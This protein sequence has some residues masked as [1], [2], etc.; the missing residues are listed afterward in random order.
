M[1]TSNAD[2][3]NGPEVPA[4]EPKL[5]LALSGGGKRA[6]LFS[7]GALLA[8]V[9]AGYNQST[10]AISSVSGGSITNGAVATAC[11]FTEVGKENF[12][13]LVDDL[14]DKLQRRRHRVRFWWLLLVAAVYTLLAATSP[15]NALWDRIDFIGHADV[16]ESEIGVVLLTG[17]FLYVLSVRNLLQERVISALFKTPGKTEATLEDLATRKVAHVFCLTDLE[18]GLPLLFRNDKCLRLIADDE[19]GE[20]ACQVS[21]QRSMALARV[22]TG[23]AA[24]PGAFAPFLLRLSRDPSV[25]RRDRWIVA[26]DGGVYNNL[27]SN[28][29]LQ[30]MGLSEVAWPDTWPAETDVKRDSADHVFVVDASARRGFRRIRVKAEE[31]V[32]IWTE[33]KAF[34]RV[35]GVINS[36][37]VAHRQ[38]LLD[39]ADAIEE[40]ASAVH[41]L[42]V[43]VPA[44]SVAQR[45]SDAD[46]AQVQCRAAAVLKAL[47]GLRTQ[48]NWNRL[49]DVSG[50][51]KTGLGKIELPMARSLLIH[52]YYSMAATRYI[53]LGRCAPLPTLR[54]LG[55]DDSP[56][57]MSNG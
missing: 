57:A 46:S 14:A 49:A 3:T 11:D 40:P 38:L 7:L 43:A 32:S 36:S 27:A 13:D 45:Y 26:S 35:T 56:S 22:V 16:P 51:V 37:N 28:W 1:T 53:H 47:L 39:L 34:F 20:P 29:L 30:D 12:R 33:A 2:Q 42:D 52:G 10:V 5:A 41:R 21:Q 54:F 9:E 8:V 6:S 50:S 23:S 55:G 19:T 4:P 31:G 18:Y 24:F 17:G 44:T 15:V 48:E 25:Q